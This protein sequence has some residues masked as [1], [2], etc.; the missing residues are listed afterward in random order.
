VWAYPGTGG[1][2]QATLHGTTGHDLFRGSGMLG[3]LQGPGYYLGASGFEAVSIVNPS[4]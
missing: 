4:L 2:D 3:T 1:N